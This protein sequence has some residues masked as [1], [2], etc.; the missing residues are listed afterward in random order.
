M[1]RLCWYNL[2]LTCP[3]IGALGRLC[4]VIV[5]FPGYIYLNFCLHFLVPIAIKFR[6][7][8]EYKYI[9]IIS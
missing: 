7:S 3:S 1:W 4:F 2:L 6:F 8:S 5:A 9:S